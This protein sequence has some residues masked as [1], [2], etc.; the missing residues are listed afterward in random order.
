MP[1]GL[2]TCYC[3]CLECSCP[4]VTGLCWVS[5]QIWFPVT[6]SS[7]PDHAIAHKLL[8]PAVLCDPPG[9]TLRGR[10]I[11]FII[12]TWGENIIFEWINKWADLGGL[13][14]WISALDLG[15]QQEIDPVVRGL[16]SLSPHWIPSRQPSSWK[17][18]QEMNPFLH[19]WTKGQCLLLFHCY[20]QHSWFGFVWFIFLLQ[21]ALYS[22][23]PI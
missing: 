10:S 1:R 12:H 14:T 9:K 4:T 21:N 6:T 17:W 23:T 20:T 5:S 13:D 11:L 16:S 2:N 22:T 18:F 19:P 7:C 3:H 8:P 15:T